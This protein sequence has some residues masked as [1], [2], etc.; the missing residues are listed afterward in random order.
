[1][2]WSV[3]LECDGLDCARLAGQRADLWN[4]DSAVAGDEGWWENRDS[5]ENFCDHC[6][7][8]LAADPGRR[9]DPMLNDATCLP[10]GQRQPCWTCGGDS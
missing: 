2:S 5:G 4:E 9:V 7:P 6:G 3:V 8:R 1:M 10:H